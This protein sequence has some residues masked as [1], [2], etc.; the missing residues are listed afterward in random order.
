MRDIFK[1]SPVSGFEIEHLG[2]SPS[3]LDAVSSFSV[4][5]NALG[6]ER[7]LKHEAL[8]DEV[9]GDSRSYLVRDS[10]NG[11]IACYFSLRAGLI[12]ISA[13]EGFFDTIP[14]IELANFAVNQSYRKL[15]P[16]SRK[17]GALVFDRFVIG[18]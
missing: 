1:A 11:E 7:Y 4:A 10:E 17:I 2:A 18:L 16:T 13:G 5:N 9:S 6:L 3:A 14:A 8:P 12:T 15:H